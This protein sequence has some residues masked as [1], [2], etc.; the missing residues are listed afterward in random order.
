MRCAHQNSASR[1][2]ISCRP[3]LVLNQREFGAYVMKGRPKQD[4]YKYEEYLLVYLRFEA[5]VRLY[6][7]G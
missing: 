1:D 7:Q 4:P 5:N 6:G 3:H 2:T